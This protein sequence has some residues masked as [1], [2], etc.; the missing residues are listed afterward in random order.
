MRD[1]PSPTWW[2]VTLPTLSRIEKIKLYDDW[3]QL[4]D[5]TLDILDQDMNV[6]SKTYFPG[7]ASGN[8]TI[9]VVFDFS[10]NVV[11]GQYV[12][13]TRENDKPL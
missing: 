3:G 9:P 2:R 13:V 6:I 4:R 10:D 1:H 7:V 5:F 11:L 12:Q 8:I